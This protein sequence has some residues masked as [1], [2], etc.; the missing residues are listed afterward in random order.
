M[1]HL[2]IPVLI[3][4]L[5]VSI[6]KAQIPDTL[7]FLHTSDPHTIF[8]P[9]EFHPV[10]SDPRVVN[11]NAGDSLIR[12]FNS[13]PKLLNADAVI[14]TGDLIYFYE[15]LTKSKT[16]LA[17]QVEQFKSLYDKCPVP[18]Y[19]TLG[20]HD[21]SRY[22]VNEAQTLK[23]TSQ[24]IADRAR[25]CWIRNIPCFYNGTYYSREFQ[26]GKA[27]YHFIFLENGFSVD[28]GRIIEK[29]QLDWF[30]EEMKNSGSDPV[31]LLFHS[32]FSVGDNN[33]DGIYFARDKSTVWPSE[34]Q[35]SEGFLK[36]LNES[37]NIKALIVGHGHSNIFEKIHFPGGN[38]IY[39]VET[40]SVTEK[41][42]YWRLLQF[43]DKEIIISK[44]GSRKTEVR[45]SLGK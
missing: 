4:F 14:V 32:Y 28:G 44:P 36:I 41:T 38:D 20:N 3:A 42:N 2:L 21:I 40:G 25:A 10:L 15:G 33:N 34:K 16:Y 11:K 29:S 26:I 17:G 5:S 27:K 18:L 22:N 39:Q 8:Y 35:C 13:I 31:V 9:D 7:R 1:K 43:T 30:R 37:E 45:I 24:F 6:V 19:L 23:A 12:F